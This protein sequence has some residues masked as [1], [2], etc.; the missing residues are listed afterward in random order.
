MRGGKVRRDGRAKKQ[1]REDGTHD[2]A[3]EIAGNHCQSLPVAAKGVLM[4]VRNC[5]RH[6]ERGSKASND[7][8]L[9]IG[10][11]WG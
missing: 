10:G 8:A 3:F 1:N 2:D 6:A 11:D 9:E 7:D 4:H 5:E